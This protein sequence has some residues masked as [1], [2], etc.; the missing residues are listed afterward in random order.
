MLQYQLSAF[1]RWIQWISWAAAFIGPWKTIRILNNGKCLWSDDHMIPHLLVAGGVT[2]LGLYQGFVVRGV[3]LLDVTTV[4][5]LSV[6]I[7][8]LTALALADGT[9]GSFVTSLLF[10]YFAIVR[11]HI[12]EPK[13]GAADAREELS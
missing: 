6:V 10:V 4:A 1:T 12:A 9:F 2:A 3:D 5:Y 8:G 11:P 7:I 13:K